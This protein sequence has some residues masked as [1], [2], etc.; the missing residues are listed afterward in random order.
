M[1]AS[2]TWLGHGSFRLVR[3]TGQT[4][5]IDPWLLDNPACPTPEHEPSQLDA[6]LVTHGH[7]DHVGDVLRLW[8][9][10]RV[11]VV[12]PLEV[13]SWLEAQGLDADMSLAPNRGGT[14]DVV[15]VRATYTDARHSSSAPD[16]TATGEPCGIVV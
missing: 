15:G 16:G 11:P 4:I 13:R 10:H 7:V 3:P 5:Y 9:R 12:A 14:V 1:P 6:I 2:L 8:Q